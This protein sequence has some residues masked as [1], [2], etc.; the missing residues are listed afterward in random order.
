M[1]DDRL[2]VPEGLIIDE[3]ARER[4]VRQLA[5]ASAGVVGVGA[6][7]GELPPGASYRVHAEWRSLEPLSALVDAPNGNV[8]GAV[9]LR[10][11]APFE[12]R[13][14]SV[15]VDGPVLLD[16]GAHVHDPWAEI[17]LVRPASELGRPPFPRRPVV[18]FAATEADAALSDWARR[19]VNRLIRRDVEGRLAFPAVEAGLHLTRPC[20]PT[21]E[22]MRALAP[23]VVVTLDAGAR[24]QAGAW[25]G[26]D[27]STVIIELVDDLSITHRLV[28]W[29][30]ERARGRVRAQISR[31]VEAPSLAEL[32]RR[33]CAGPQ[34]IA[35]TDTGTELLASPR[36]RE[37]FG[38]HAAPRPTCVLLGGS[39]GRSG[40]ARVDGLA[41]HL[42]A[43]GV[44]VGRASLEHGIPQGARG[45]TLV[46]IA[47]IED[48]EAMNELIEARSASG[49]PTMIDILP[50]D[51]AAGEGGTGAVLHPETAQLAVRCGRAA[52]PGGAAE[53]ALRA[54]GVRTFVLPALLTRAR[55]TTLRRAHAE[56]TGG[57]RLG[58]YVGW[59]G[60][61]SGPYRDAVA[62][63]VAKF[64]ADRVDVCV[65]VVG[66]D[67]NVPSA[68]R[69]HDRVTV[70]GDVP[71]PD[72]LA[73]W[74][75]HV[76][77]PRFVDGDVADDLA[78]LIEASYVGVPSVMPLAARRA[79][80]AV[81]SGD[82]LITRFDEPEAWAGGLR[83]IL[84]HGRG[85]AKYAKEAQRWARA[86]HGPV[87]AQ[88]SVSRMV[89]WVQ[90]EEQ[91]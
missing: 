29:Q 31:R 22:S 44:G 39:R 52:A 3:V 83:R 25:C 37:R 10:P 55:A 9:L 16:R 17:G 4:L 41:D 50:A 43:A 45:A 73:E 82:F 62:E 13:G 58:W 2:V 8:R 78:G 77:T 79:M 56:S 18:V 21:V 34:P 53:H 7:V 76:W 59:S 61:P 48:A 74:S 72:T 67:D 75:L 26:T 68:L 84:D 38:A 70:I 46:V 30:I 60:D 14:D 71:D 66:D 36:V 54:L 23:D 32:V 49:L 57:T 1:T 51:V 20:L 12:V 86:V 81:P 15:A 27:R 80:D 5:R 35:P 24:E 28:S 19:L 40:A 11:D 90:F 87:A 91:L 88:A 85:S 47:G 42:E 63:G 6:E 89:G 69:R 33:L 65:D 64:L